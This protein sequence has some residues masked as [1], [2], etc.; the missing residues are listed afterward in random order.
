MSKRLISFLLAALCGLG[1][2]ACQP[3]VPEETAPETAIGTL[4]ET[5]E[6]AEALP[7]GIKSKNDAV[8]SM[9][10]PSAE[11]EAISVN[12]GERIGYRFHAAA[13]FDTLDVCCPS[14]SNN[15]GTLRFSLYRWNGSFEDSVDAEALATALY[16]DYADNATLHFAFPEQ[17]S[18]EYL[19]VLHDAVETVGVWSFF[20]DVSGGYIYRDGLESDG[21]FQ[22]SIHYAMTPEQNFIECESV[23]DMSYFAEAPFPTEYPADHIL[24]TR[25]AMPDTWDAT[26]GLGRVL[27]TNGETGDVREGKFVGLFY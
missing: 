12:P 14:W 2:T 26:D 19:L 7:A 9:Y 3:A 27:P 24:N 15:I 23:L 17:S 1:L 21:E 20:S 6:A 11:K 5:A 16:V 22:A 4:P 25:D 18:G 10:D 13:P 8:R